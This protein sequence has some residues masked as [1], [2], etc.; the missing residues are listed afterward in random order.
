VKVG[1][2][3]RADNRGLGNVT[4]E[5]ARHLDVDRILIIQM[6]GSQAF[7]GWHPER[8]EGLARWVITLPFDG[9]QLDKRHVVNWLDGL[10]VAY[11]AETF[12][13]WRMVEWA[14][15][16][17]VGTV[18]HVMP[19]FFKH[20]RQKDLPPPT[21]W[22]APTP[23]R[24]DQLPNS[25]RLVPV[26]VALD[27]F[28]DA[29]EPYTGGE[30]RVLHPAGKLAMADRNGTRLL[31]MTLRRAKRP[32]TVTVLS[33]DGQVPA[34]RQVTRHITLDVVKGDRP[35]YWDGYYGHHLC[36]IPRQYGGLC[37]PAQEAAAAGLPLMMTDCSPNDW[38]PAELLPAT[39]TGAVGAPCG[40]LATYRPDPMKLAARLDA[41][42][43]DELGDLAWQSFAWA[44]AHSWEALHELWLAELAL[45]AG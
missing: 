17:G 27:R 45:A 26:P 20:H 11:S 10:D 44:Q 36:V 38:Y 40:P 13:D 15:E 37:L 39:L 30:L 35:H 32:M 14:R 6:G 12:Y 42:T 23:W 31:L 33:Q 1:L 3:V 5:A 19:E 25:T 43:A 2:V 4:W 29:Y 22:W 28:P 34:Y 24:L 18:C 8:Y 9:H 21:A 16:L 41:I 7:G